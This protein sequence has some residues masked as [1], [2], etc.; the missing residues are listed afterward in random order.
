ME[1]HPQQL[2]RNAPLLARGILSGLLQA[3]YPFGFLAAVFNVAIMENNQHGWRALYWFGAGPPVLLILWRLSL[4][5]T[6]AFKAVHKER[7]A[8]EVT[9]V[10]QRGF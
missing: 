1:M 8:M 9:K 2:L 5:E 10:P 6:D 3:G 7:K 4:P